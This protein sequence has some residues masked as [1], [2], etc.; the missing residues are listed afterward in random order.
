MVLMRSLGYGQHT[1]EKKILEECKTMIEELSKKNEEY[2]D[3]LN[4][5]HLSVT[6]IICYLL[7]NEKYGHEDAEFKRFLEI[8]GLYL[9][10]IFGNII[11]NNLPVLR[12]L[13][14]FR[15]TL[16][17]IHKTAATLDK[18]VLEKVEQRRQA[19]EKD[20]SV[21]DFV[22]VNNL[23]SIYGKVL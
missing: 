16:K 6:N 20:D 4:I 10:D 14:N 7:F 18:F 11:L 17:R 21:N 19:L 2:F 22:Q 15:T 5:I 13:P 12:F 8:L 9:N 3:P 23:L 1:T